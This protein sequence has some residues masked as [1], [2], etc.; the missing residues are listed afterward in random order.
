MKRIISI[1]LM[2]CL[3]CVMLIGCEE[4]EPEK[5]SDFNV[6]DNQKETLLECAYQ[7]PKSWDKM[8]DTDEN[9][10]F[11][12]PENGMLMVYYEEL[13]G[14]I[15]D[16]GLAQT[17]MNNFT[18]GWD[19][20]KLGELETTNVSGEK[21]Y[22]QEWSFE[23]EG[24][25]YVSKTVLFDCNNGVMNFTMNT[26]VSSNISYDD[27]FNDIVNSIQITLPFYSTLDDIETMTLALQMDGTH[28]YVSDEKSQ[29]DDGTF[30]QIYSERSSG[31]QIVFLANAEG[32]ITLTRVIA[33]D[34]EALS[35]AAVV[36]ITGLMI[37]T[38]AEGMSDVFMCLVPEALADMDKGLDNAVI[39]TSGGI[40]YTFTKEDESKYTLEI[41]RDVSS[42]EDYAA[43][44]IG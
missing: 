24:T 9:T 34:A 44:I 5:A 43:D 28:D 40:N 10:L 20:V 13:E 32:N 36:A 8:T 25:P 22:S 33:T 35:E 1:A 30:M 18:D 23:T 26:E 31:S 27:D 2:L 39:K 42:K 16:D 19:K 4:K 3:C 14:S 29:M 17:Y 41:Q 7:I 15:L 21:A 11:Y 38:S 12:C 6:K 37:D